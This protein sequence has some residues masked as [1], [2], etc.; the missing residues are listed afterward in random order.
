[1]FEIVFEP[2]SQG[3]WW[4]MLGGSG[5]KNPKM[6]TYILI[7]FK[8]KD[9]YYYYKSPPTLKIDWLIYRNRPI[10][11]LLKHT[12]TLPHTRTVSRS[13]SLSVARATRM[14]TQFEEIKSDINFMNV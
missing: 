1:M 8:H 11:M 5:D 14:R 13:L 12:R 10:R 3:G 7:L 9:N 4:I 6:V 2:Q